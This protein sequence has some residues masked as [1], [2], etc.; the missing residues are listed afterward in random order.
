MKKTFSLPATIS[1]SSA[2]RATFTRR[3]RVPSPRAAHACNPAVLPECLAEGDGEKPGYFEGAGGRSVSVAL[4][5]AM[6]GEGGVWVMRGH[7]AFHS[8]QEMRPS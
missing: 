6:L 8:L 2:L 1:R 7:H 5:E 3:L 4:S